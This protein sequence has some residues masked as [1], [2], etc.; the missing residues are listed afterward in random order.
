M[1]WMMILVAQAGVCDLYALTVS[2]KTSVPIQR[3]VDHLL[4]VPVSAL[5]SLSS[6]VDQSLV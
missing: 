1:R 6:V 3:L 4:T 2:S 5:L